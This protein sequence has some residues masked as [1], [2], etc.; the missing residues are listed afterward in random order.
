MQFPI[1]QLVIELR[2]PY[3]FLNKWLKTSSITIV[4]LRSER[5]PD[6]PP[7]AVEGGG[8]RVSRAGE[9]GG[10]SARWSSGEGE[11][12]GNGPV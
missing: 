5:M 2:P 8:V 11:A 9:G 1:T 6:M 3:S 10:T 7:H 4:K 12:G